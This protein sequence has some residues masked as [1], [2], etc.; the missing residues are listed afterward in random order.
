M[1]KFREI[2][3]KGR[4][5]VRV[6]QVEL[7]PGAVDYM[8]EH[9]AQMRQASSPGEYMHDGAVPAQ[10]FIGEAGVDILG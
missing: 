5:V 10:E 1:R 2:T 3:P 6:R 8:L 4:A 7:R 9:M